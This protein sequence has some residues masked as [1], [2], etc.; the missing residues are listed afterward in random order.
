MESEMEYKFSWIF[1]KSD[2]SAERVKEN[3]FGQARW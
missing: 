1:K 3:T 2:L